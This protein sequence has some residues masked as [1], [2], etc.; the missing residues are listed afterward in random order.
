LSIQTD[1]DSFSIISLTKYSGV[2]TSPNFLMFF[3]IIHLTTVLEATCRH[4]D[5]NLLI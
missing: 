2:K 1:A 5:E 4:D 3:A